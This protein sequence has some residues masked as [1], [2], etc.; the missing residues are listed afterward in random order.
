MA[1]PN[2]SPE[3]SI[4]VLHVDDEPGFAEMVATHLERLDD[5]L[6]IYTAQHAQKGLNQ[7]ES[8]SVDCIVSD[9]QMPQMDGID[10][11]RSVRKEYPNLPFL[12]FTGKGSEDVAAEATAAGVT[13]YLKK[14]GTTTIELLCTQIQ[15][16]VRR[17]R[18]ERNAKLATERLH[19]IFEHTGGFYAID[20]NWDITY[21]NEQMT[22]RTGKPSEDVVGHTLWDV[23]TVAADP[24]IRE[25]LESV[26]ET[27]T[28]AEFDTYVDST[29]RWLEIHVYP[30][31]EGVFIRSRDVTASKQ[32]V[33]MLK[34]RSEQLE[35][36]VRDIGYDLQDSLQIA[37]GNL[38]LA[39]E[40]GESS[41]LE[42]VAN[43]H[44]EMASFIGGLL[45]MLEPEQK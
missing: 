16:A 42:D 3:S 21:W 26:H 28:A 14:E 23:H 12:L 30:V 8:K 41:Y 34:N 29:D 19:Q 2:A 7:L 13:G 35:S 6:R 10:F 40:T 25:Q 17:S 15:E 1:V 18:A 37:Q 36:V 39:R 44:S 45:E 31:P 27:R 20:K 38:S 32:R 5:R 22:A 11:L 43:T 33:Q 4:S 9:Y 24:S